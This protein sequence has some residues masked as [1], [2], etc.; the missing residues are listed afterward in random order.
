MSLLTV[1]AS[2]RVRAKRGT[3]TGSAKPS[4]GNT[5]IL[6]CFGGFAASQ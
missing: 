3:M 4:R 1:I 6:D 2:Q 5:K